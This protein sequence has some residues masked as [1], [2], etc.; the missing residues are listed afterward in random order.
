MVK[1]EPRGLKQPRAPESPRLQTRPRFK[2]LRQLELS[3]TDLDRFSAALQEAFPTIRFMLADFE[4]HW[5]DRQYGYDEVHGHGPNRITLISE[6]MRPPHGD[7]MPY[8]RSLRDLPRDRVSVWLEPPDWKPQWSAKPYRRGRYVLLNEPEIHF[9]FLRPMYRIEGPEGTRKLIPEPP[10]TLADD[11]VCC[12][13]G[14]SMNGPYFA[15]QI[16]Q[17]DFL[18][19]VWRIARKVTTSKLVLVDL[20]S[21]EFRLVP[22]TLSLRAGLDAADWTRR[23]RRHLI[24]LGIV[25]RAADAFRGSQGSES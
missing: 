1:P 4:E 8:A 17:Q 12:L 24:S 9:I 25:Y 23:D 21:L 7:A 15:D 18:K 19:R 22:K 5:I 14:G 20:R 13:W 16:E 2:S 11:E 3:S 6:R 10:E